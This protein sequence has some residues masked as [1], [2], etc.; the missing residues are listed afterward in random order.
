MCSR[1]LSALFACVLLLVCVPARAW[2]S[3]QV[4]DVRARVELSSDDEASV[5]LDLGIEVR[6]GWLERFDLEGL[7]PELR[8]DPDRPGWLTTAE[9]N[10]VAAR[11]TTHDGAVTARFE[12]HDAARRGLHRLSIVYRAPLEVVEDGRFAFGLPGFQ[13]SLAAGEISI[14]APQGI[15]AVRDPESTTEVSERVRGQRTQIV[16]R[17]T[18][19]PRATRWVV[20]LARVPHSTPLKSSK[21]L[22]TRELALGGAVA[23]F[24]LAIGL[25]GRGSFRSSAR[26]LGLQVEPWLRPRKANGWL[27]AA[28]AVAMTLLWPFAFEISLALGLALTALCASRVAP[29]DSALS[30]TSLRS[31]RAVELHK[32][33]CAYF[34]QVLGAAPWADAFTLIGM[35]GLS[36][37]ILGAAWIGTREAWVLGI[38]CALPTWI[39]SSQLRLPRSAVER[40]RR[41]LATAS[42]LRIDGCAF[43]LVAHG[44]ARGELLEARLRVVPAIRYA[45]LLRVDLCADSRRFMQKLSMS[46]VVRCGSPADRWLQVHFA[47]HERSL[48][49]GGLRAAYVR[50]VSD[51]AAALD[52]LFALLSR[53][54]QAL[55]QKKPNQAARAA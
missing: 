26:R 53:E 43:R 6:G 3:A 21:T 17:R 39:A 23:A 20:E 34:R 55:V 49:G 8:L 1:A 27:L 51:P 7:S 18:H 35:L 47:S 38:L 5:L 9:G 22:P 19:W 30:F 15:H 2:T 25:L 48:S 50:S 37:L 12:K 44:D 40:A 33:H 31:L 10:V 41:L 24:L 16:F 13:R 54:S 11:V 42:R 29:S 4:T 46:V 36:A 32:L 45:G 28:C 52:A 14:D